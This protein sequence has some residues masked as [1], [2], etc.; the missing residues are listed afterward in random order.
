LKVLI[1]ITQSMSA[2]IPCL[3]PVFGKYIIVIILLFSISKI[4]NLVFITESI[5]QL[6]EK[7]ITLVE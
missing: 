2:E 5:I 1:T 4:Y 6:Y 7:R 3:K